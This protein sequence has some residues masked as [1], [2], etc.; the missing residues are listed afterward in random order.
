MKAP[1]APEGLQWGDTTIRQE[2]KFYNNAE[3]ASKLS[4]AP[5]PTEGAYSTLLG[6]VASGEG[7]A[8]VHASKIPLWANIELQ[9]DGS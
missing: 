9:P 6:S 1:R 7:L 8:A 4:V 3:K 5:D 2:N